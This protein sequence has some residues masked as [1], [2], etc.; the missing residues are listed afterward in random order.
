MSGRPCLSRRTVVGLTALALA[1]PALVGASAASAQPK[2]SWSYRGSGAFATT[3]WVQRYEFANPSFG[4]VHVGDL[5]AYETS[6]GKADVFAWIDDYDCPEGEWPASGHD[7]PHGPGEEPS[8][9]PGDDGPLGTVGGIVGGIVGGGSDEPEEATGC[10]YVGS[11]NLDG[12]GLSFTRTKKDGSARLVGTLAASTAGDPH[13]GEGGQQLGGA[14]ADVVWTGVGE[15]SEY[16]GTYRFREG[17]TSYSGSYR[18]SSRSA[19]MSGV[20]GPMD[21]ADA[22]QA[23]GRYG[24]YRST[25]RARG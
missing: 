16:R 13:T 18:S 11:R 6:K 7:E 20:L 25:D 10:Q 9:Q 4:N 24:T 3:S 19:T 14:P 8:E 15:V 17:G 22:H 23:D 12:S 5:Y 2:D 21:F 1:L